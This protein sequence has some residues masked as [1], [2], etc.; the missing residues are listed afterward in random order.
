MYTLRRITL[1]GVEMN[2]ELGRSYTYVDRDYAP[3]QFQLTYDHVLNYPHENSDEIF[4]FISNE[5]GSIIQPLWKGQQNFVMT[6][7]GATLAKLNP[8]T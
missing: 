6:D 8:R 5:D 4:G 7:R 1:D 3:E 2:Q